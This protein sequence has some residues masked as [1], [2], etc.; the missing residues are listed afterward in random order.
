MFGRLSAFLVIALISSGV[1]HAFT[2]PKLPFFSKPVA[3]APTASRVDFVGQKTLGEPEIRAAIAEQIQEIES[4]GVTPARADDAAYYVGAFYRKSGFTKAETSYS[5]RGDRVAI[6][7]QEGPRTLLRTVRFEGNPSIPDAT[8][9]DY[10]IGGKPEQMQK[11]PEDFPLNEKELSAGADRVRG[12]YIS[13]GYLDVVVD[14]PEI[15]FA[16][17][18]TGADVT[19]KI[20][21]GMRYSFGDITFSGETIFPRAELL[22][23]AGALGETIGSPYS[24]TQITN[25][26]RNLESHFKSRGYY[27]ASVTVN[28][29]PQ[30]AVKGAIPVTFVIKAGAVY[31]FDGVKV[32]NQ[33]QP[34]LRLRQDFLPKRFRRLK[35]QTFSPAKLDEV[36][37][38]MLRSG[39]FNTM[40]VSTVPQLDHTVRLELT[41]EEAK[42]KEVGFTLGFGTYDGV[43]AGL[44]LA[45]RNFAGNGR[46][47]SFS[48]DY[49]Q[50]GLR[51]ELLYVDPWLFDSAFNLRAKLFSARRDEKGYSKSGQGARI[52]LGRRFSPH[53]EIAAFAEHEIARITDSTI[54]PLFLGPTDY[55]MTSFGLT[56]TTDF[57]DDEINPRRGWIFTTSFGAGNID[58]QLSFFRGTG[59][60]SWY[61]PIGKQCQLAL[62]ARAGVIHPQIE[63]IP[64]DV[65]FFNGGGNSVRSF[66]ERELGPKD[67]QS[68]PIGGEFFS[69]F[70]AEFT[71]PIY[72]GL[73]GATFV[74]AGNLTG[75]NE[76]GVTDLRYAVGLGLR[77][78][79]PVGPLRLDYGV[80]PSPRKGED[81][82]AFHFSFGFAF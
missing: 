19:L 22:K 50:R 5:I 56:Q 17:D 34:K 74:D 58:G 73:A 81:R 44:R 78:K 12:L 4:K 62:G 69:V 8:L 53:L 70:N 60:F 40:R 46:P 39:L 80:N 11:H 54:D 66:G 10:M 57:R 36:Y 76:A 55:T 20:Q 21:E 38:E 52:D 68:N 9:Y 18:R 45:D 72:G 48:L 79:L 64:I 16:A 59:R 6:L 49:A 67:K 77:Y 63:Q 51:G 23:A 27:D 61:Q 75:L 24:A 1:A 43:T 41:V 30:R 3:A 32:T 26:S 42:A 25:M 2:F 7:I 29:E 13:E 35:G 65:R 14:P 71:F 33:T 15:A 37:R 28:A 31:R 47:L 82:G